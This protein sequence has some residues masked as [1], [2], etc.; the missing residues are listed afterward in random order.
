MAHVVLPTP[1]FWFAIAMTLPNRA[2]LFANPLARAR[3]ELLCSPQ[4][5]E[6]T[7][8]QPRTDYNGN[9]HVFARLCDENL[10]RRACRASRAATLVDNSVVLRG[11]ARRSRAR[12]RPLAR[13]SS[14]SGTPGGPYRFAH[15]PILATLREQAPARSSSG[16]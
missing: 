12:R 2:L 4:R 10:L 7:R 6:R 11:R 5:A 3:F 1:P 8:H 15:G 9:V 13:A 16:P 14:R